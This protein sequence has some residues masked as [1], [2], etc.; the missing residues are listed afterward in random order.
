M[1]RARQMVRRFAHRFSLI[2]KVADLF[3]GSM[4]FFLGS[5]FFIWD[6]V[7]TALGF[8]SSWLCV[9]IG[10]ALFP[11]GRLFFLWGSTTEWCGLLFQPSA[12]RMRRDGHHVKGDYMLG[13]G[14]QRRKRLHLPHVHLP[15]THVHLPEKMHLPRMHLPETLHL[16][17]VHPPPHVAPVAEDLGASALEATSQSC[18]GTAPATLPVQAPIPPA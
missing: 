18:N 5:L 4:C 13:V 16:P 12:H 14:M 17:R 7:S 3:H 9:L 15:E 8:G 6:S 10:Y 1:T 2:D 11:P